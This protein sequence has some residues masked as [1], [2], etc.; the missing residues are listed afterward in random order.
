MGIRI[1]LLMSVPVLVKGS[2]ERVLRGWR[3]VGVRG[4]DLERESKP[5]W[6]IKWLK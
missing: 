3:E 6:S 5:E 1:I 2:W 4:N